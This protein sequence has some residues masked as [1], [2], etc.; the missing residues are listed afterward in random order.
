MIPLFDAH[1]DTITAAARRGEG[2]RI[3]SCQLDLQRLSAYAPC[4]QV[5]AIF[6]RP[7]G[8]P[9]GSFD[10]PDAPGAVLYGLYRQTLE[11]L[12]TELAV[13]ADL[14]T[15]CTSAAEVQAAAQAGKIAALIA[16]EGAELLDCSVENLRRAYMDGVRLVNL[17]WNYPNALA[18]TALSRAQSGLTAAGRAFVT[19][20][21]ELGVAV[22]LS[23]ASERTFWDTVEI[24]RRPIL[25]G[26]SNARALCGHPRNLTDDQFRAL[27]RLGGCAGL[28]LCP[29][30]LGLGRDIE[31]VV[32]HA[33]HF[34]ALGGEKAVCLGGD[35]DG[36][37]APPAG[38]AGVE[39]MG[40]LYEA[41]LRR[42][43]SE[44]LV[45]DIFYYNL[46]EV[47]R[48]AL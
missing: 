43:W 22:D 34:L 40:A 19:A 24:A 5:F 18:G 17:T 30:F 13:N 41:M 10:V 35:L 9:P 3:N 32:A 26:H 27:V 14:V 6:L 7:E 21:Q 25:A 20:A 44:D 39:D 31:A 16:V 4:A 36:I 29:D 28:N 12:H 8:E 37:D 45:R 38:I 46:L 2:L 11:R 23:H 15:L 42:N 48:K 33:E 1:C 47:L